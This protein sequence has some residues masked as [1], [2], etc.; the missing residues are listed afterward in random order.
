MHRGPTIYQIAQ[1]AGV[2]PSTAARILSGRSKGSEHT[3]ERVL[4]AAERLG[5]RLNLVAQSL[6][7]G[8]SRG[9]G[10]LTPDI[11]DPF[12]VEVLRGVERGLFDSGY[13][14]LIA[15]GHWQLGENRNALDVLLGHRVRGL[16][17]AAKH[18]PPARVARLADE[19]PL[20][21]VGQRVPQL[22]GRCLAIDNARAAAAVVRHLIDLGHRRIAYIGG[23]PLHWHTADRFRGYQEALEGASIDLVP[24]L[25]RAGNFDERSGYLAA[26][27][28]VGQGAAFTALFASNDLMAYGARLALFDNGLAVPDDVSLV[29]FDDLPWSP[30]MVPPLTTWRQPA[31]DMGIDAAR[32][33]VALLSGAPFR[34][35]AYAGELVVRGTTAAPP[36][37]RHET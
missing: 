20:V 5:Y 29:G 2:S 15:D 35:A 33:V 18:A 4:G 6:S 25:V 11:G 16:I 13:Y 14:P 30:Y 8:T 34:A 28:L 36:A 26:E 9:I 3:R 7:T 27:G 24:E 37:G 22:D 31:Y 19:L 10:V 21:L 23:P 1:E 17:V 12:F 32:G